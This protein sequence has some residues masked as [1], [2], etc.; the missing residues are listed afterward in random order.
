MGIIEKSGYILNNKFKDHNAENLLDEKI[1]VTNDL[2]KGCICGKV[3]LGK[4]E[5]EQCPH[6]LKRC[7]P[8][9]AIGPCMV[10]DEGTCRIRANYKDVK[11]FD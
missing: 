2:P 4:L 11:I 7:T 1:E 9:T 3:I 10:S 6:F 8:E 5:P